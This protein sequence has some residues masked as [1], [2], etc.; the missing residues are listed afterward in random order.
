MTEYQPHAARGGTRPSRVAG[1]DRA[2]PV[3]DEEGEFLPVR[4]HA[5]ECAV[6]GAVLMDLAFEYRIDTDL[7]ALAVT[8]PT[9]TG[10]PMLDR[11]LAQIAART[12]LEVGDVMGGIVIRFP[13]D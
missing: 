7:Q 5:F 3:Q 12:D 13:V 6:A 2:G 1:P 11:I 4:E 9:P 8:D 10:H